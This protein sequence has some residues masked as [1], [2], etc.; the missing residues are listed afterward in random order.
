MTKKTRDAKRIADNVESIQEGFQKVLAA[1]GLPNIRISNFR[2]TDI[3]HEEN[4]STDITAKSH[5]CW[6]WVC[7]I[8][9]TG[10]VCHKVWDPNC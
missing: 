2:L 6:K 10:Q 8:T 5:G 3:E 4:M 7:E 9:P 1:H